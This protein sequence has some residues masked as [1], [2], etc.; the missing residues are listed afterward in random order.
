MGFSH[1]VD[2]DRFSGS[3]GRVLVEQGLLWR[4]LLAKWF[5]PP[6]MMSQ[7]KGES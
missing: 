4:D 1:G 2:Q 6:I 3:S 7:S 5:L